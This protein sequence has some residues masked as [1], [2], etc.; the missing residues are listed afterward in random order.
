MFMKSNMNYESLKNAKLKNL[1]Y[2]HP[3]K[4]ILSFKGRF[5]YTKMTVKQPI[6]IGQLNCGC[7]TVLDGNNRI[8]LILKREIDSKFEVIP[9][10]MI[11]IYPKGE[12]DI[13]TFYWWNEYPKTFEVVMRYSSEINKI[14]KR[15][16]M[17]SNVQEYKNKINK[18]MEIIDDNKHICVNL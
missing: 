9:K 14:K 5:D 6:Q 10:K 18:Y 16:S 15:K 2:G 12:W 11:I 17:F 8:G 7:W 3:G 13:D 1:M 4:F